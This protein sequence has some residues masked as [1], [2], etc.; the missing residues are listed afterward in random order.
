MG[1]IVEISG[2]QGDR[3]STEQEPAA[4]GPPDLGEMVVHL[5]S[6][7]AHLDDLRSL[8]PASGLLALHVDRARH[9][10]H[11]ALRDVQRQLEARKP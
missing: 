1:T 4:Q 8:H 6:A 2:W 5:R 7:A 9:A 10:V 11:L 3:G